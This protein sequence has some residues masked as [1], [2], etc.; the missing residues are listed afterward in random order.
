MPE[1]KFIVTGDDS[2]LN[3]TFKNV[4]KSAEKTA[5]NVVKIFEKVQK[6]APKEI[7]EEEK[8]RKKVTEALQGQTKATEKVIAAADKETAAHERT[9]ESIRK[10][11]AAF[12]S[13]TGKQIRPVQM[14]STLDEVNKYNE[15][16]TGTIAGGTVVGT[17]EEF[18]KMAN[19]ANVYGESV[20][21]AN[22]E[23]SASQKALSSKMNETEIDMARLNNAG[24]KGYD[25][26]GNRITNTIGKQEQ[27]NNKLKMY[28]EA[29]GKAVAPQSFANLNK[30]IEETEVQLSKL[31]NAGRT[32]F[33]DLGNKIEAANTK[34]NGFLRTLGGIGSALGVAFGVYEL[35]SFAKEL[36][37]ISREASGI[38]RAFSRM[39][40]SDSLAK[41]RKETNGFVSDLQLEKL[42]VKANNFNIP[43]DKLGTFLSFAT[44]RAKETGASVDQ[45][46]NNI[47]DG[48]GR[49]SPLIIDNLGISIV[50]IRKE[51]S[52]TGDF[53]QAVSNIIE[54]EMGASGVAVDTLAD[55]T[56]R[57][58][59]MWD[60]AKASVAGFFSKIANPGVADNSIIAKMTTEAQ[61]GFG[62]LSKMSADELAK[63]VSNQ[64]KVVS[65]LSGSYKKVLGEYDGAF[66]TRGKRK[67]D[68][69][70]KSYGEQLAAAQN[71]LRNLKDQRLEREKTERVDKNILS[72]AEMEQKV[73]DLRDKAKNIIPGVSGSVDNRKNLLT[74]ADQL[75]KQID[76]ITGKAEVA[77]ARAGEKAR[78]AAERQTSADAAA[79]SAQERLQQRMQEIR[80]KFQRQGLSKEQEARKAI[81]DEF[82]KLAFDIEQQGNKYDAYAK[83]Y[84]SA[85]A[86]S[87]LGPKQ[88][89]KDLEPVK[90]AAMNDLIYRQDTAKYELA[91]D[92]QREAYESYENW[93]RSFGVESA[94]KRFGQELDLTTTYL[95][96]VK[97]R[98]AQLAGKMAVN[99]LSGGTL[100][101]PE[102]EEMELY[103]KR[104]ED[105]NKAVQSKRDADYADAYRAAMTFN[106]KVERINAEYR[107]K[108]ADLGSSITDAQKIELNQ[109][110]DNAINSAKDEALAK[111]AVYKKLAEETIQLTRTQAK[112]QIK[113]LEDLMS[114][115]A[116][117]D[118]VKEKIQQQITNL[119]FT[120]KIGVDQANLNNLKQEYQD[121]IAELNATDENGDSIV[122]EEAKKRIL[123][124]LIEVKAKI[125]SIDS[126][127]D[128][129]ASWG[130]KVAANFEYFKGST[131][132]VAAGVANDLGQI[133]GSFNELSN[134]LGGSDTQAGYLL[135]TISDLVKVGQ[136]A[137][138][139]VASFAA[140]DVVGGVTKTVSAVA[141][142]FSIGKKVKE[143]NAAA[144]KEVQDFYEAAIKGEMEYQALLR[145]REIDT[146]ARGKNS[147]RAIIDQLEAIKKQSPEVQKAYDKIFASLQGEEY[148]T[149]TGYKHGTWFR[150]AKT[151]D[152]MASL[153]GSDYKDLEERDAKGQ[154]TGD[155]KT[156]FDNLKTLR[157]ELDAVGISAEDL[158]N[159]LRQLLTGTS[160]SGLADGLASLFEN[161][162]RSA[163]DFGDSF[164]QIMKNS[165]MNT[166]KAKYLEDAMQPFY[167]ELAALMEGGTPTDEQIAGLKN[168]YVKIGQDADAYLENIEKIT[169]QDLSSSD[170][171]SALQKNITQITSDQANALEGI[172]RGTYDYTKRIFDS[173]ESGNLTAVQQLNA[174]M[175][176]LVWQ[177]QTAENTFRAANNTERLANIESYLKSLSNS[178]EQVSLRGGGFG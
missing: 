42:T 53:V 111:T 85:R 84:G 19:A 177:Q 137:A 105:G 128:S 165:I 167:E 125:D 126:D 97:T 101:G 71:V 147:Y 26:L 169:G 127:G 79:L 135:G 21:K 75:Q 81:I 6:G 36:F 157:E 140:G 145:K 51:V 82:T 47:I 83:K 178:N 16:K 107:K 33:D 7:E 39:G 41:L 11:N 77:E 119:K 62:D 78:L 64:E 44:V 150:K 46:T 120:L 103:A 8:K 117:P 40:D 57:M 110:R 58:L 104:L 106:I 134:A 162:K 54:R 99:K 100:S 156:N 32:G 73:S 166:F 63:L 146:A 14:S 172:S 13:V 98:Y 31:K 25:E 96:K 5:A 67:I 118:D 1:L 76:K 70:R 23:A 28:Q 115:G 142:L 149:G 136:D 12:D 74:E 171:S 123:K 20:R 122:S 43:I 48:L 86:L 55:K 114:T 22:T 148:K 49:K 168:K 175:Q 139:A 124:R 129:V 133:S 130:D 29:L 144:R 37:G 30:K 141:G 3:K 112:E 170:K 72:M 90:A 9:T 161:G 155:A 66:S 163:Q 131:Q 34:G 164:E 35:V 18:N 173:H 92:K 17:V 158:Q 138:G 93:K 102:K 154:L 109:Q 45:L 59:T 159:D 89:V 50:E 91:L 88:T 60:N 27:L 94:R 52:R 152:I 2:H 10:K 143:M 65:T 4:E 80:D 61:K 121:T 116:L 153:A 113:A 174:S 160:T 56:N 176:G 95:D 24:R 15:G 38:E 68:D 151:W 87:V 132:E 108:A 69:D